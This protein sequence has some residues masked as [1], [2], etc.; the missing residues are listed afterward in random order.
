MSGEA[1]TK[2]ICCAL[3]MFFSYAI[4]IVKCVWMY[5]CDYL[6]IKLQWRQKWK[7]D[8]STAVLPDFKLFAL[9]EKNQNSS[10]QTVFGIKQYE[11]T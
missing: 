7:T 8:V 6:S 10:P 9:Y 5:L 11:G 1:L 2:T 3:N 4:R